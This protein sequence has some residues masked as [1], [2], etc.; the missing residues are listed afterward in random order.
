MKKIYMNPSTVEV[1]VET[2]HLLTV[3][4]NEVHEEVSTNQSYSREGKWTDE[5]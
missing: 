1:K 5:D 3:S 4:N 2:G